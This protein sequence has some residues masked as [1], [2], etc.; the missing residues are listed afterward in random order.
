MLEYVGEAKW[1]RIVRRNGRSTF[2]IL[3]ARLILTEK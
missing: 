1:I 2:D 3:L